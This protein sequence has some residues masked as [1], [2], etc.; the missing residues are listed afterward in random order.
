LHHES[1]EQ[2]FIAQS[3]KTTVTVAKD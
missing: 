1:H 2:C 3:V